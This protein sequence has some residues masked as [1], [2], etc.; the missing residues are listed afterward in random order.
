MALTLRTWAAESVGLGLNCEVDESPN[1]FE[2]VSLFI[3][4]I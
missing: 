3:I 1:G 4:L 2:F